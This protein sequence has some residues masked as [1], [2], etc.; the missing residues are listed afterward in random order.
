[1]GRAR[2][3][4]PRRAIAAT[5]LWLVV[6][7]TFGLNDVLASVLVGAVGALAL[8]RLARGLS[9]GGWGGGGL[10]LL[11]DARTVTAA[12]LAGG[13]SGS[14]SGRSRRRTRSPPGSA[15]RA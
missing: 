2:R 9:N 3:G 5:A 7:D 12:L 4:R 10:R 13:R 8:W 14:G 6:D 15:G 1:L 11:M